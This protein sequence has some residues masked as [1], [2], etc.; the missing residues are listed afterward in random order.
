MLGGKVAT[1]SSSDVLKSSAL[2]QLFVWAQ[3]ALSPVQQEKDRYAYSHIYIY[4][5]A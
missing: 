3:T 5:Y 1:L 2:A 4:I